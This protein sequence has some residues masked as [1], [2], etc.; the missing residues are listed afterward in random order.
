V[1]GLVIG[2]T[3]VLVVA[4]VLVTYWALVV[5]PES[6]AK[7]SLRKRLQSRRKDKRTTAAIVKAVDREQEELKG[8]GFL[9]R[10]MRP[11]R[12]MVEQSGLDITAGGLVTGSLVLGLIVFIVAARLTLLVP[13]ASLLAVLAVCIPTLYVRY[14][15]QTRMRQFEEF[16]PEAIDL[17][18]RALRAGHA[19]T[20]GLAMVADE[21]PDPVASEFRL[22]YDQQN[23]GL[24]V[25]EAMLSFAR[26][27]PLLDARFF[28]TAV[29]TQRE[30]GGNLAEVLDNLA[31]VIRDRFRVKRQVRVISAHGR[32]SGYILAGLPPALA[33][34]LSIRSPDNFMILFRDPLGIQMIIVA[35]VL[36]VTGMLIIRR[37]VN[38]E[39]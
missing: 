4:I 33:L 26:R 16:F 5:Q 14:K 24:P 12:T 35:I 9:A 1:V 23:Y 38:I 25:Q 10:V 19:F 39:Y 20:T 21:I 18:A 36:Q 28:V 2:A 7:A 17:I 11:V 15:R 27:I 6:R 32:M 30:A 31:S 13:V 3:F 34:L 37:I 8:S 29:L 22:L